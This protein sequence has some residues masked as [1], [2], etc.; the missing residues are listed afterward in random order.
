MDVDPFHLCE[1]C[2]GMGDENVGYTHIVA[3]VLT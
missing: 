1:E 2:P 3:A